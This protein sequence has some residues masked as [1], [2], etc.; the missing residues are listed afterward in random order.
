[1]SLS[2]L[3]RAVER[4]SMI[5]V[6]SISTSFPGRETLATRRTVTIGQ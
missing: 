4:R 5:A 3:T 1:M 2:H 6:T